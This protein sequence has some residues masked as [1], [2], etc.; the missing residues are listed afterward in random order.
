MSNFLENTD[1]VRLQ[2]ASG[3]IF[4]E[5]IEATKVTPRVA[6]SRK[7]SVLTLSLVGE[8][9]PESA[10]EFYDPIF[11]LIRRVFAEMPEHIAFRLVLRLSYTNT[12]SSKVLDDLVQLLYKYYLEPKRSVYVVFEIESGDE[13]MVDFAR[14]LFAELPKEFFTIQEYE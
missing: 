13:S 7:E 4:A 1:T 6:L 5:T 3:F 14:E 10:E 8:S 2:D 12:S 9:Y 11:V